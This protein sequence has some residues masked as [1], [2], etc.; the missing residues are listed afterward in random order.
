MRTMAPISCLKTALRTCRTQNPILQKARRYEPWY[1]ECVALLL[2]HAGS[3]SCK[4]LKISRSENAIGSSQI[5]GVD[6]YDTANMRKKAPPKRCSGNCGSQ[7]G[8]FRVLCDCFI[9]GNYFNEIFSLFSVAILPIIG[10][11][12]A[13]SYLRRC[14]K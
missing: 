14:R 13:E 10:Y 8:S 11:N 9:I 4:G 12:I 5:I 3:R 1:R 2:S 6:R 7:R